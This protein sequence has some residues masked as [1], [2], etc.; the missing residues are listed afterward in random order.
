MME[1]SLTMM[2]LPWAKTRVFAVPRS[3][4]RSLEK[5]LKRERMLWMREYRIW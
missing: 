3:M 1:G 5:R 2:P 4:A